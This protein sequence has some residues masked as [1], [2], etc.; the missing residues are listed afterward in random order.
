MGAAMYELPASGNLVVVCFRHVW[1]RIRIIYRGK[2]SAQSGNAVV[3]HM[4]RH[5]AVHGPYTRIVGDEFHVPGFARG[6]KNCIFAYLRRRLDGKAV[7][8]GDSELMAVQMNRVVMHLDVSETYLYLVTAV[9][10]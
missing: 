1:I 3:G 5:M 10:L 2:H 8:A 7:C 6:D 9:H 4:V